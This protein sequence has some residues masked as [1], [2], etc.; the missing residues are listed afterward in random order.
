MREIAQIIYE[1]VRTQTINRRSMREGLSN[2][3]WASDVV[4]NL[5][6][7]GLVQLISL[8][9][10]VLAWQLALGQLDLAAWKWRESGTYSLASTYL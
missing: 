2:H 8:W 6:M 7:D 9:K 5:S 1:Q 10:I 3:R 4:S